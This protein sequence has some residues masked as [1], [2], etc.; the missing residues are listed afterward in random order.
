MIH[1]QKSNSPKKFQEFKLQNPQAHFDD[2]P[3]EVKDTF[4]W[5]SKVRIRDKI[6]IEHYENGEYRP[7]CGILIDYLVK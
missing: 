5:R 3:T 6:K 7:Y 1:I 4:C 2:M